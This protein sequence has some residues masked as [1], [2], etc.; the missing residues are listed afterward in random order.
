M[1]GLIPR[2]IPGRAGQW[3]VVAALA[4]SVGCASRQTSPSH[5]AAVPS[6]PRLSETEL[7]R[8]VEAGARFAAG[9]VHDLRGEPR[10]AEEQ[11]RASV[12]ADPA[13]EPLALELAQRHLRNRDPLAAVEVLTETSRRPDASAQVLGWLGTA[14]AQATNAP[15]AIAAF[16]EA[17][18]REP[19]SM[20]GY[21]GLATVHLQA[22]QTNEALAVLEEGAARPAPPA[23]FLVDLAGFYVAAGR[24]RLLPTEVTRPRALALLERAARLTP[25][26]PFVRERLAEGFAV[27]GETRRATDLYEAL[28]RDQPSDNPR[29]RLA[30][31]E[32]LFQLHMRIG[33]AAEARRHLEAITRDNPAN[34]RAYALLG[35]LCLEEKRF[36][37]AELN[38]EK[39]LL[40]D[41]GMEP[42]YYD[43]AGVKLSLR[44]PHEA[45]EILEQARTRFRPGFLLEFYS[46]VALA[47]QKRYAEA[48]NHYDAAE[49]HARVSDPARLNDFFY[50]QVGAA[51]E[52]AGRL[53]EAEAA[54]R[55]CLELNPD[56]AEALNYLSYMWAERGQNLQEAR[57]LVQRAL[58]QEPDNYA[59]L[60]TLAWVLYQMGKPDE[61]LPHQLRAVELSPEPD[62]TL[63]DHLGDIYHALGREAEARAAWEKSLA[64]EANPAVEKKLRPE[65]AVPGPS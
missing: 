39:A 13:H 63:L 40:L 51:S 20:L 45:W 53:A 41:P 18:R 62:A 48:L 60:D 54:L 15:A 46:G 50:F 11:F 19:E 5:F 47:A 14:Y 22:G 25:T 28:L 56:H 9:L 16:R 24:Q 32:Q 17:I 59:Y 7:Q 23:G 8:R 52:R 42:V 3:L 31:H 26:D 58:Q 21:H 38:F 61:A 55:R 65:P 33:Q 2:I 1:A 43:L 6:S 35:A 10:A 12:R 29:A 57:V 49:L 36:A 27:L 30:L 34:P 37:E 44:K 64:V 4:W